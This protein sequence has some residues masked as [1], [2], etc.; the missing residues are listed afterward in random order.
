MSRMFPGRPLAQNGGGRAA[1]STMGD[2]PIER[3]ARVV[4][5]TDPDDTRTFW[6]SRTPAQRVEGIET[7]RAEAHGWTDDSWPRLQRVCRVLRAS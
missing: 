1:P 6:L 4:R 7:L 2:V 5:M 3:V